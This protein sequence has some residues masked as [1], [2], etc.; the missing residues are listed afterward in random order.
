L[1]ASVNESCVAIWIARLSLAVDLPTVRER[2]RGLDDLGHLERFGDVEYLVCR[3]SDLGDLER[4]EIGIA[5][6]DAQVHVAVDRPHAPR[7]L[8]PVDPRRH[9]DVDERYRERATLGR[10]ALDLG[11]RVLALTVV[12]QLERGCLVGGLDGVV[13]EQL[14]RHRRQRIVGPCGGEAPPIAVVHRGFVVDDQNSHGA[15]NLVTG[16]TGRK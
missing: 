8:A 1:G 2:G 6:D 13:P 3:P 10:R 16:F 15:M 9:A 12:N 4:G 14:A 5:R 11:D 7:G